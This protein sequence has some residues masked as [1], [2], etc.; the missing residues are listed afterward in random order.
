MIKTYLCTS[1]NHQVQLLA[2]SEQ[3]AR[4]YFIKLHEEEPEVLDWTSIKDK[5]EM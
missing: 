1:D 4:E 3:M 2:K 5:Y